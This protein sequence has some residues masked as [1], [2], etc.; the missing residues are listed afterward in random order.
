VGAVPAEEEFDGALQGPLEPGKFM[1]GPP[2]PG[3]G[4]GDEEPPKPLARA[5]LAKKRAIRLAAV[6]P[7]FVVMLSSKR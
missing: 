6:A 2:K 5:V 7:C 1:P 3:I 4:D